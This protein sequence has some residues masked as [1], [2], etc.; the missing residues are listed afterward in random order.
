M[1]VVQELEKTLAAAVSHIPEIFGG[2]LKALPAVA[3]Q[4][5][6]I[7]FAV[8]AGQQAQTPG[9]PVALGGHR[10]TLALVWSPEAP[11][12]PVVA[13]ESHAALPTAPE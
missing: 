1:N 11:Q 9:I 13:V 3:S 5:G 7:V 4:A 2:L 6:S 10:G 8:A 12:L